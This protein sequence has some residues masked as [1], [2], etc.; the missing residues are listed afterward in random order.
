MRNSTLERS[1]IPFLARWCA[2]GLLSVFVHLTVVLPFTDIHNVDTAIA[3]NMADT[4][5]ELE[6]EEL[7][8]VVEDALAKLLT[9]GV[10]SQNQWA[11]LAVTAENNLHVSLFGPPPEL[12]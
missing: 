2:F 8:E 1:A 3:E 6:T 12:I 4:E 11:E 5:S 10:V 9:A 7:D